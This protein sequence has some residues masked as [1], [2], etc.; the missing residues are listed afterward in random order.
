MRKATLLL[1]T[2]L[3]VVGPIASATHAG[4][5]KPI[6]VGKDP[7]GDWSAGAGSPVEG[8]AGNAL[9]Q[10]LVEAQI[11]MKD[12]STVLFV[13]KVASLPP[14]G[15]APE[16]TRYTWEMAVDMDQVQLDGKF[17]NYSRGICDPTAGTCP[18][19]RNPGMSP[20]FV[21]TD[22]GGT[23]ATVCKEKGIVQAE[24]DAAKGTISIPVPLKL[25]GGKPGSEITGASFFFGGITA[26]PSAFA[27]LT[28]GPS[29]QLSPGKTFVVPGG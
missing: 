18:P 25:L 17:T 8:A 3:L 11:G 20:F 24:F 19:P 7:A 23:G 22:C 1:V 12:P 29:D 6:T 4:G 21:R 2:C 28:G 26:Q 10:D 27:S 9:S 16:Y 15:G 13:I 14:I 5:T